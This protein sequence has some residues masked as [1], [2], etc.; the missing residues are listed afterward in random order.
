MQVTAARD[1]LQ[2]Q[3]KET[4]ASLASSKAAAPPNQAPAAITVSP[5]AQCSGVP[6]ELQS[7]CA[8]LK[9]ENAR[10]LAD[11]KELRSTAATN[12]LPSNPAFPGT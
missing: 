7:L 2:Q 5:F 12:G 11:V 6:L 3:L 8:E 10:L 1:L 9:A 4:Q